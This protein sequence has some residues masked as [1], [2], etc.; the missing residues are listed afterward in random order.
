MDGVAQRYP[1]I[2]GQPL[3]DYIPVLLPC[4]LLTI[5]ALVMERRELP[6]TVEF[7]LK[8][9]CAGLEDAGEISAFLGFNERFSAALIE[10][11]K[12]EEM[13][14]GGVDG[15]ISLLRKGK[16]ALD[17]NG[18]R[19]HLDK[20]MHVLWDPIVETPVTSRQE[21]LPERARQANILTLRF[22]AILRPPRLEQLDVKTIQAYRRT[23]REIDELDDREEIL[24]FIRIKKTFHRYRRGILLFYES[25]DSVPTVKVAIDGHLDEQMSSSLAMKNVGQY[26]GLDARFKR[27]GGAIAVANRLRELNIV[28]ESG[29]TYGSLSQRRSVLA[30]RIGTISRRLEADD[31]SENVRNQF[32]SYAKELREI[33]E[34]LAA[35]PFRR[36]AAGELT[37]CLI[38]ALQHAKQAIHITTTLPDES[39]FSLEVEEAL[40]DAIARGVAIHIDIADRLNDP[41]STPRDRHSPAIAR[42]NALVNRSNGKIDICF[43]RTIERTVFEI[44]WDGKDLVF[45]NDPPLGIRPD[46]TQPREFQGF[47]VSNEAIA[48]QYAREHMS[49]RKDEVLKRIGR[50]VGRGDL[51]RSDKREAFKRTKQGNR[52]IPKR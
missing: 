23:I 1:S 46:P 24:R 39:R 41:A 42:L 4:Q 35:I 50:T 18:D 33:E 29:G 26:I 13:I 44:Y 16:E 2:N 30:W 3:L 25:G 52:P 9:V 48:G 19:V 37:L 15:R 14:T 11:M 34:A 12:S 27:R 7:V 51:Q 47:R 43:L 45:S 21:I 5:D 38:E 32:E 28:T 36:L 17:Q 22:P 31:V 40:K 20:T 8:A 10:Q 6:S 49:S